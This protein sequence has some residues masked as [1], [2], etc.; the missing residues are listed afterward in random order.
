MHTGPTRYAVLL[1]L[2]L[3]K[4]ETS[5]V[6][7]NAMT[8]HAGQACSLALVCL[9]LWKVVSQISQLCAYVS[10]ILQASQLHTPAML[11]LF[12]YLLGTWLL[13]LVPTSEIKCLYSLSRHAV[14]PCT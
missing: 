14:L 6:C 13:V 10:K 2:L 9:L 3:W 11:C 4:V 8:M 12:L 1:Y 5:Q 7:H